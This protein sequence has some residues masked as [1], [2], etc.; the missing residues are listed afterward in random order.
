[1]QMHPPGHWSDARMQE[2]G[3]MQFN[4]EP[5]TRET[6]HS[7]LVKM[8]FAYLQEQQQ[9]VDAKYAKQDVDEIAQQQTHL[10][11]KQ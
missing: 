10:S 1:M 5:D 9:L 8:E 3:A 6:M 2:L 7:P 11:K 4:D